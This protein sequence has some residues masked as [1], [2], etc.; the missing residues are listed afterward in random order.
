MDPIT[1]PADV[2]A[3]LW[4][5]VADVGIIAVAVVALLT[6][7]K[8]VARLVGVNLDSKVAQVILEV[9]PLL[10]GAGLAMAPSLF[11]GTG[12]WLS[13]VLGLVAGFVSPGI[14]G[15]LK[16]RLP[17]VMVSRESRSSDDG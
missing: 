4:Q 13:L 17:G 7:A 8:H 3:A 15:F 5:L 14:Y 16:R 9:A 12:P 2:Q 11:E 6:T 1:M 10:L